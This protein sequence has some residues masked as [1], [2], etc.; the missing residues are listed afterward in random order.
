M[1]VLLFTLAAGMMV[2]VGSAGQPADSGK[3]IDRTAIET[4]VIKTQAATQQSR[5]DRFAQSSDMT[6]TNFRDSTVYY[7]APRP[8]I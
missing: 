4:V 7:V 8:P 5:G 3:T 6:W 1:K 2:N